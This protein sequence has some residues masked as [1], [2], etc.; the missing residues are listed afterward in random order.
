MSYTAAGQDGKSE[1]RGG[2]IDFM[3]TDWAMVR[4]IVSLS[5]LCFLWLILINPV[6]A[7]DHLDR[8][9]V[10]QDRRFDITG[11]FAFPS[12]ERPGRLVLIM[13][14]LPEAGDPEPR[15]S[16]KPAPAESEWFYDRLDYSFVVRRASV[17]GTGAD[18][19]FAV[20][21][22]EFRFSCNFRA[23]KDDPQRGTCKGPAGISV[24]VEVNDQ[25]GNQA[26]GLRVFAG[27][28]SDPFFLDLANLGQ[29]LALPRI[30]ELENKIGADLLLGPITGSKNSLHGKDVLSIVI[31]A[32]ID[33][34]FGSGGGSLFAVVGEVYIS[35]EEPVRVD[36]QGRSEMTNITLGRMQ[37]D[38]VN[39]NLEIRDWYKPGGFLQHV[40][41][42]RGSLRCSI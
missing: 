42:P 2:R 31:E 33:K 5:G 10:G 12:P 1:T 36:R 21:D 4:P 9:K 39:P 27:L 14:T 16:K 28:R 19:E 34:L 30:T 23:H 17:G 15:F 29:T 37:S 7:S 40:R 24:P 35:G 25:D 13:N 6:D 3:K 41:G 38:E 32:D 11:V 22:K 18:A 26:Q 20:D 8:P